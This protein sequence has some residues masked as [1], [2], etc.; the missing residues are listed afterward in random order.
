MSVVSFGTLWEVST[1]RCDYQERM[2]KGWGGEEKMA[3]Q[4]LA[5][6]VCLETI[7]VNSSP[8]LVS[9]FVL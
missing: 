7:S 8:E 2:F 6:T 1:Q 4:K 3:S 5:T 9:A